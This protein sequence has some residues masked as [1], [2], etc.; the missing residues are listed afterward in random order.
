MPGS[1]YLPQLYSPFYRL[2]FVC[3]ETQGPLPSYTNY[4]RIL[5]LPSA[6]TTSTLLL[7]PPTKNDDK[8]LPPSA[9]EE[10]KG[11]TKGSRYEREA[12]MA[13]DGVMALRITCTPVRGIRCF[14]TFWGHKAGPFL[15]L[16]FKWCRLQTNGLA[17][18]RHVI[19]KTK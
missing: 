3:T 5:H 7:P 10:E 2:S 16:D 9:E 1:S 6:T 4:T 15:N 11:K 14:Q 18:Q 13:R 17:S 19:L 8:P 12:F